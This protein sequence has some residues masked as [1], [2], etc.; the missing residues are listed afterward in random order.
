MK[1]L[2]DRVLIEPDPQSEETPSGL[3]IKRDRR[4]PET[5]GTVIAIGE[6]VR[7]VKPGDYVLFSW[8]VGQEVSFRDERKR[9]LVMGER[10]I[11]AVFGSP[12]PE[13]VP[14]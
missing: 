14:V 8:Q 4:L 5:T 1:P 13:G 2:G 9:Y 12:E 11:L 3:I 7:E 10:D 6:K